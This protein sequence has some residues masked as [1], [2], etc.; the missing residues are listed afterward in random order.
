MAELRKV[1]QHVAEIVR[2]GAHFIVIDEVGFGAG[3]GIAQTRATLKNSLM[4]VFILKWDIVFSNRKS[5]KHRIWQFEAECSAFKGALGDQ[6]EQFEH[7]SNN[8][9]ILRDKAVAHSDAREALEQMADKGVVWPVV[10][11]G[12]DYALVAYNALQGGSDNR[13]QYEAMIDKIRSIFS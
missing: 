12:V 3:S 13:D 8:I 7:Y 4:E 6:F 2:A 9:E 1:A 11:E 5:Q 10:S